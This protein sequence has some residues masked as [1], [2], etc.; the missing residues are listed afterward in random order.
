MT[1]PWIEFYLSFKWRFEAGF[2]L[3]IDIYVYFYHK[4]HLDLYFENSLYNILY[5]FFQKLL[6]NIKIFQDKTNDVTDHSQINLMGTTIDVHKF[7]E[8]DS[9]HTFAGWKQRLL[10]QNCTPLPQLTSK[11]QVNVWNNHWIELS[12]MF[13]Q[14]SII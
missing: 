10:K 1:N 3:Y 6:S 4:T 8:K 9:D 12:L 14:Y 11:T 13:F 5:I 7:I 2:S